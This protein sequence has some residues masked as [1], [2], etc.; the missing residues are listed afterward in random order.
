MIEIFHFVQVNKPQLFTKSS[1]TNQH[2]M[3]LKSQAKRS[4][5]TM[6]LTE[7]G[8]KIVQEIESTSEMFAIKLNLFDLRWH[9]IAFR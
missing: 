2:L 8:I 7:A 1:K 3:S 6:S 9:Q 4:T 5:L